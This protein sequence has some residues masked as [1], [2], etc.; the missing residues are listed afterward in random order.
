VLIN[1]KIS[2]FLS[3]RSDNEQVNGGIDPGM[4]H[5]DR[6]VLFYCPSSRVSSLV[7]QPTARCFSAQT[8]KPATPRR[9]EREG[10]PSRASASAFGFPIIARGSARPTFPAS[11][12][13]PR[14]VSE[15]ADDASLRFALAGLDHRR[16][17]GAALSTVHGGDDN[18]DDRRQ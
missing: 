2:H 4:E 1:F 11:P 3:C 12:G 17:A 9:R 7:H 14:H 10:K 13:E 6:V 8:Q 15:R 16:P 5:G 18:A